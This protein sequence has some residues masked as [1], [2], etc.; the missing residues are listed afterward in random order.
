MK[1]FMQELGTSTVRNNDQACLILPYLR[2]KQFLY[3]CDN[4]PKRQSA[5]L[6]TF[7]FH[8]RKINFSG[9]DFISL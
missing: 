2:S 3:V 6:E 1:S 4:V 8:I 7:G 5:I 9:K